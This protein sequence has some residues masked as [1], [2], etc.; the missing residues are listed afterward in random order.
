M[1]N[2][3]TFCEAADALVSTILASGI[4]SIISEDGAL[5][6]RAPCP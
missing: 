4:L 6:A 1:E 3:G 2:E 5:T